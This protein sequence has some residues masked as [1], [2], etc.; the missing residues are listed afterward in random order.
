VVGKPVEVRVPLGRSGN[1]IPISIEDG[2]TGSV[3]FIIPK[4]CDDTCDPVPVPLQSPAKLGHQFLL[5]SPSSSSHKYLDVVHLP[6][7]IKDVN[8]YLLRKMKI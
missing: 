6:E 7:G 8:E 4:R 3:L 5:A 2:A 1:S